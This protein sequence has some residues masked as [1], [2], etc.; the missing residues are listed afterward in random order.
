MLSD[1]SATIIISF[2]FFTFLAHRAYEN[3]KL[4]QTQELNLAQSLLCLSLHPHN[5]RE[6]FFFFVGR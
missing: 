2:H 6:R 4:L 5:D 1:V 3:A